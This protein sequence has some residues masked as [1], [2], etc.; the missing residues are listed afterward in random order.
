MTALVP[1]VPD[2]RSKQNLVEE[3]LSLGFF[4]NNLPQVSGADIGASVEEAD[5]PSGLDIKL[6]AGLESGKVTFDKMQSDLETDVELSDTEKTK[7]RYWCEALLVFRHMQRPIDVEALTFLQLYFA[8][9]R[10]GDIFPEKSRKN[11]FLCSSGERTHSVTRD[12]TRF[13]EAYQLSPFASQDVR[14]AVLRMAAKKLTAQQQ[15]AVRRH[16][17][18]DVFLPQD[19]GSGYAAGILGQ[20]GKLINQEGW[21]VNIPKIEEV[22]EQWKP[23]AKLTIETDPVFIRCVSEQSGLAVKDFGPAQGLEPEPLASTSSSSSQPTNI[24]S[25]CPTPVTQVSRCPSMGKSAEPDLSEFQKSILSNPSKPQDYD[26]L[27]FMSLVGTFKRLPLQKKA[28][29]PRALKKFCPN[30]ST[31]T[32]TRTRKSMTEV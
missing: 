17:H 30:P 13:L 24:Q 23:A 26:E 1:F 22:V 31:P 27:Y 32:G 11:F 9:V 5:D 21:K 28:K 16:M 15:E 18:P 12:M 4:V 20:V 8:K 14:A 29:M 6:P 2:P 7:Y 19:G 10:P 25:M 3:L